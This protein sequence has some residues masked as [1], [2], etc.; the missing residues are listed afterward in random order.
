VNI[1]C[2]SA[3][4]DMNVRAILII[5]GNCITFSKQ[6]ETEIVENIYSNTVKNCLENKFAINK[7]EITSNFNN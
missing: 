2:D 5:L 7:L 6:N 4:P 3:I 1:L